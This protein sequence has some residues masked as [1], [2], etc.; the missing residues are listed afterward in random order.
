MPWRSRRLKPANLGNTI[1]NAFWSGSCCTSSVS[2]TL[3]RYTLLIASPA[4]TGKRCAV[5]SSL[6]QRISPP[7]SFSSCRLRL[8]SS[9]Y[10]CFSACFTAFSSIFLSFFS[11]FSSTFIRFYIH[12]SVNGEKHC[13]SHFQIISEY[14]KKYNRRR[15]F[16]EQEQKKR[17]LSTFPLLQCTSSSPVPETVWFAP[18]SDVR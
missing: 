1:F 4:I 6:S 17:M 13:F 16:C 11:S 2:V 7:L 15:C 5:L 14:R 12:L 3:I 10:S 8:F 9:L 18:P